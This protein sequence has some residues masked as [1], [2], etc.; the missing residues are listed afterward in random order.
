MFNCVLCG[1]IFG[2]HCRVW[3]KCEASVPK[4]Y[5]TVQVAEEL[6]EALKDPEKIVGIQRAKKDGDPEPAQFFRSIEEGSA[7][8]KALILDPDSEGLWVGCQARL[9]VSLKALLDQV[10]QL[11]GFGGVGN[12]AQHGKVFDL[13]F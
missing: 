3:E 8:I 7:V 13:A 1:F 4:S 10:N 5:N 6:L 2:P 9:E 11:R 12:L